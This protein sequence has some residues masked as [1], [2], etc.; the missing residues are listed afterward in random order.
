MCTDTYRPGIRELVTETFALRPD[1]VLVIDDVARVAET[2]RELGAPFVG[3]PS[4][5]EQ[6]FQREAM[7][8]VGVRHLVRS[9][10]EIGED[11]LHA[12][13]TEAAAGTCWRDR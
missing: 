12:L 8:E 10:A 2:A 3:I 4:D 5:F 9:P 13:D 7:H 1:R 6:G 11:L